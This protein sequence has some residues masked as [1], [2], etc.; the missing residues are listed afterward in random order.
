MFHANRFHMHLLLDAHHSCMTG[1]PSQMEFFKFPE[2]THKTEL[3]R[4]GGVCE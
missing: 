1:Q 2:W 4:F 3:K